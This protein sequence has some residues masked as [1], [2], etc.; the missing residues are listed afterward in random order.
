MVFFL[1]SATS[2]A[3]DVACYGAIRRH[4]NTRFLISFIQTINLKNEGETLRKQS[5]E[6][7][8]KR[9]APFKNLAEKTDAILT[10]FNAFFFFRNVFCK[11]RCVLRSNKKSVKR[12]A[13][14]SMQTINLKK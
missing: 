4:Y 7:P 3:R 5:D 10:T 12:N 2:P 13:I 1:F 11:G 6:Q 14:S 9:N 8:F